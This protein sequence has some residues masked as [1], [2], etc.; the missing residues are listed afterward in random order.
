MVELPS[1]GFLILGVAILLFTVF[2]ASIKIKQNPKESFQK[3]NPNIKILSPDIKLELSGDL[4][5]IDKNSFFLVG[6]DI[7]KIDIKGDIIWQKNFENFNVIGAK[8]KFILLSRD[9]EI[10]I[11]DDNMQEIFSKQDFLWEPQVK[12]I[13]EDAFLLIGKKDN[14]D[15]LTLIDRAGNIRFVKHIKNPV[16][17]A[18]IDTKS[19]LIVVSLLRNQIEGKAIL[20][21]VSGNILWSITSEDIPLLIKLVNKKI[22]AVYD[23]RVLKLNLK[24]DVIWEVLLSNKVLKADI[25]DMGRTA[26]V[27]E[28]TTSNLSRQVLPRLIVISSEGKKVF[29][30]FIDKE[31]YNIKIIDDMFL[32]CCDIGIISFSK[33]PDKNFVISWEGKKDLKEITTSAHLVVK[34]GRKSSIIKAPWEARK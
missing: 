29:S 3:I 13:S 31:P 27:I 21:D 4:V 17:C 2:I 22:I 28:D 16:I 32:V 10:K 5:P 26:L 24:G 9:G 25:G 11:I 18:D 6:N 8:G 12:S 30:Y 20:L 1:K 14:K 23:K 33:N 7:K 15:Y 34:Q 19:G